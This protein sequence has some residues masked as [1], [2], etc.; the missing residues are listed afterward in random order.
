MVTTAALTMQV[1]LAPGQDVGNRDQDFDPSPGVRVFDQHERKDGSEADAVK[2]G[3]M[4]GP[5]KDSTA[6][7]IARTK[8]LVNRNTA[9]D[10]TKPKLAERP[11]LTRKPNVTGLF[12]FNTSRVVPGARKFGPGPL[13]K[14]PVGEKKKKKVPVVPKKLKPGVPTIGDRTVALTM[15]DPTTEASGNEGRDAKN[16]LVMPGTDLDTNRQ[17]GSEEEI[18]AVGSKELPDVG[19]AGHGNDTAPVSPE[20]TGTVQSQEKKCMNKVKVTHIRLP[21]KDRGSGCRGDGAGLVGKTPGSRQGSD[22]KPSPAE[23]DLDYSPDPL[24][25]LL[26][27]TFDNLNITTFSVHLSEPSD[28]SVDSDRVRMQILSGLK[29]LSSFPPSSSSSSTSQSSSHSSSSHSSPSS[30]H[31]QSSAAASSSSSSSASLVSSSL[32]AAPS[33]SLIYLASSSPSSLPSPSSSPSSPPSSPSSSL[34]SSESGSVES[35]EPDE[36]SK[37][38]TDVASSEDRKLPPSGKA[39]VPFFRRTP[40]KSGFVRRP[41]PNFGS[42]QNKTRLHLRAPHRSPPHLNLIPGKETESRNTSTSE[43]LS[44]PSS[45]ASEESSSVEVN[46]PVRDTSGF[47][48]GATTPASSEVEHN[49]KK[50]PTERGRIPVRRLPLKR[51]YLH[52]PLPNSGPLKNRIRPNLR[53]LPPPSQPLSPAS[54]TRKEQL[55]STELLA[56]SSP[57]SKESYPAKGTGPIGE[58]NEDGVGTS[59]ST[60]FSQTLRGSG[61]N[62]SHQPSAKVGYFRR[63]QLYGGRLPNKTRT[64]LRPPQHPYRGPVRKPFP[65]RKLNGGSGIIVGSQTNQLE[66]V[67]A[68]EIPDNQAGEQN[69]LMPTQGVQIRQSGE[70]DTVHT[71]VIPRAQT[72]A[73]NTTIRPQ[74]K[75]LEEM[76]N[77]PVQT[78]K[79]GEED[80]RTPEFNS[81]SDIHTENVHAAKNTQDRPTIKQTSNSRHGAPRPVTLPK[82]Q[83]PTRSDQMRHYISGTQRREDTKT[84]NTTK[85]LLDSKTEQT[86]SDDSK[87]LTGSDF[88]SPEVT[89][90]PL[91]YV[92]VTNRTSDGFTLTWDSPE[93]KYRNFVVTRKQVGKDG[94]PKQEQ[95]KKDHAEDQEDSEKQGHNKAEEANLHPTKE[96][97]PEKG[98]SEDE[99]R[100]PESISTGV[101][102]IQSSTAA[103]LVTGSDSTFK[104]VLPAPARSFQFE[105]LPPQ[106]EY[107]VTLLG[108]GPG[109]LSRLHKLVI[110]TGTSHCDSRETLL[111]TVQCCNIPVNVVK[112]FK[113]S[114]SAP[115]TC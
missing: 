63:P 109:L 7:V 91:D 9:K 26:T 104:K 80:T 29:P 2:V 8:P 23:T 53:L 106:T 32:T 37:G 71:E 81:D 82:R 78:A 87:R 76:A 102:R 92:G 57:V 101:S 19:M 12:R 66:K 97:E 64:N 72:D 30:S 113:E 73:H 65:T 86:R 1:T 70:Q 115:L 62:S 84:N 27:D 95:S 111:T 60:E 5:N 99:N 31:S 108:K 38:T 79:S 40:A 47:K 13:K 105:D 107:T 33:S 83:P 44:S 16:P 39:A 93:G 52:G 77:A 68:S 67:S 10:G 114:C 51:G 56:T 48:D 17:S 22:F 89:R 25:K 98:S 112:P 90:E 55:S 43:L 3:G 21:Q 28:L 85:R 4:D 34:S 96:T 15:R 59:M 46:I 58:E 24:H 6:S 35:N 100:V 14:P 88:S 20:P 49:E 61:V 18:I 50:M 54:E 94:R 74:T 103:K 110:S 75:E 69:A 11:T 45:S 36:S 42:F 41:R